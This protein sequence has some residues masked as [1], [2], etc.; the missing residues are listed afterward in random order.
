MQYINFDSESAG[1]RQHIVRPDLIIG[2]GPVD[3]QADDGNL[4]V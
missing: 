4:L 1:R 2:I 3:K